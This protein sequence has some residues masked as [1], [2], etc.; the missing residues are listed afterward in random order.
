MAK[1]WRQDIGG[2]N[3]EGKTLEALFLELGTSH[4]GAK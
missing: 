4:K 2:R 3:E 1:H